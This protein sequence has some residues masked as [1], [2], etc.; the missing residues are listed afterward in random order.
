[1]LGIDV[2]FGAYITLHNKVLV[3][4]LYLNH[5][6]LGEISLLMSWSLMKSMFLLVN[7]KL[8]PRWSTVLSSFISLLKV[9]LSSKS[10]RTD[11]N[12]QRVLIRL[13]ASGWKMPSDDTATGRKLTPSLL[14]SAPTALSFLSNQILTRKVKGIWSIRVLGQGGLLSDRGRSHVRRTPRI[15]WP[16]SKAGPRQKSSRSR[17]WLGPR[18]GLGVG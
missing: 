18:L 10:S 11:L 7:I 12:L 2:I 14:N 15:T 3:V 8:F 6:K 16:P 17:W 1:M 9:F 5:S 4:L 13:M